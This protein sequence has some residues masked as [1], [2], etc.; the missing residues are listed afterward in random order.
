MS[1]SWVKVEAKKKKKEKGKKNG[2]GVE[3]EVLFSIDTLSKV[4][5]YLPSIDVL[6]LALT[7]KRFGLSNTNDD[8]IIEESV[9]IAIQE[10]ASEEQLAALPY[11]FGESKLA[12]Y[13]YLQL[14]R[15]PL[16]FDHLT[17]GIEYVNEVDKSCVGR[18]NDYMAG[19]WQTGFSNNILR[20]GKHYATFEVHMR[21]S[22][23][24]YLG[25]MRP[26]KANKQARGFTFDKKFFQN[27]SLTHVERYSSNNNSN[28][29]CCMYYAFNGNCHTSDWE[30]TIFLGNEP[31]D[32][33]ESMSSGD[34]IGI[35]L[36]LDE[37]ILSVYKNGRKL[38]VMK[39]GLAGPYCW[40]VSLQ[41]GTRVSIKRGAVPP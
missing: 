4:I 29:Q 8:S 41:R 37:G 20:A 22:K 33:S 34:E 36:D 39:K 17:P 3:E 23:F 24:V 12:D 27:Y 18:N 30:D 40:V 21:R 25:V 7:C 1:S 5:S 31:W 11:Y 2:Y 35:L 10:I 38:G 14:M 32:G 13:H 28:V 26:G 15:E 6:N 16:A 19:T 9:C